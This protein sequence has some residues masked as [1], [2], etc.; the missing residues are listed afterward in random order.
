MRSTRNGIE[1]DQHGELLYALAAQAVAHF[2]GYLKTDEELH[3]VLANHGK[4]IAENIHAQMAQ[5]YFEDSGESEV[6]VSQGFTPLKPSAITAE[7]DVLPLHQAPQDKHR[8]ETLVYGGFAKCAYTYEKFQSDPGRVLA[9]IL[10]RDALKWLRPVVGQFNLYY[11][12]GADQPEYIA[13]FAAATADMN[14]LIETKKASV[15]QTEE[16]Q[17]KARAAAVWCAN[18]SA[19]A[20]ANVSKPWRNLL[21]PHDVVQVNATLGALAATYRFHHSA[22]T[23]N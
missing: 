21:I 12:R 23:T 14:L 16:V 13:D 22:P 1:P 11:R 4:A 10:E 8:I 20:A 18:A 3:N 7:G 2:R 19:Y 5:H 15:M 17:T 9:V 6:I